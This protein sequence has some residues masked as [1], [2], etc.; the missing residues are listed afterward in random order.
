MCAV[1]HLA[2]GSRSNRPTAIL[3][4]LS[5]LPDYCRGH[6]TLLIYSA[7]TPPYRSRE[8]SP[9]FCLCMVEN[10]PLLVRERLSFCSVGGIEPPTAQ[11][12]DRVAMFAIH[13]GKLQK[14]KTLITMYD[15]IKSIL[16]FGLVPFLSQLRIAPRRETECIFLALLNSF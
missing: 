11:T 7:S 9:S 5:A 10:R 1:P 13:M 12:A 8:T 14:K 2:C 16:R 15:T 6:T 3:L 4:Q